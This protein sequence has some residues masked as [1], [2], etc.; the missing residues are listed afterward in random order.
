MQQIL[1]KKIKKQTERINK[2]NQIYQQHELDNGD[3]LRYEG[4][5]FLPVGYRA[6]GGAPRV[7]GL[8]GRAR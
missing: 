7:V 1:Q 2:L 4:G 5:F 3:T 6:G 8:P